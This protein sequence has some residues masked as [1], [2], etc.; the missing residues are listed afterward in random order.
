MQKKK[1]LSHFFDD[2]QIPTHN[3]TE[4]KRKKK[5][6]TEKKIYPGYM[7]V[8]ME[9]NN[10]TWQ[11]VQKSNKVSSFIGNNKKLVP[12][13]NTE[14]MRML[15]KRDDNI[16]ALAPSIIYEV[17]EQVKVCDGPFASFNGMVEEVD[18]EKGKLKVSV[19]IFGRSTP[20]ELEYTQVEKM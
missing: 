11:L 8:K 17:G 2:F 7:L 19:S 18:E 1:K 10:D 9:M 5:V 6:N 4:V 12:L 20:V 3:V 15:N 14:A 16:E 13:S